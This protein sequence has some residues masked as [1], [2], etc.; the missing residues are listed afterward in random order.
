[1]RGDSVAPRFRRHPVAT[2]AL[3]LAV[4]AAGVV[5]FQRLRPGL[6]PNLE[7]PAVL[8]S[9]RDPGASASAMDR[10]VALP[11]FDALSRLPGLRDARSSSTDSYARVILTFAS[12]T[13]RDRALPRLH[14]LLARGLPL[15]AS[16]SRPADAVIPAPDGVAGRVLV[17]A[18]AWPLPA[19]RRWAEDRLMPQFLGLA[20]V[21]GGQIEGGPVR[22][23][24]VEPDP[25]RLAGLGLAFD[26]VVRAVHTGEAQAPSG[27]LAVSARSAVAAVAALPVRLP[28]G[29]LLPLSQVA[30]VR[31]RRRTGP[32]VRLN[33]SPA[34]RLVLTRM[35]GA[36]PFAVAS[37]I[38]A[39]A[40]WLDA[41]GLVPRDVQVRVRSDLTQS[42]AAL[43]RRFGVL[44]AGALILGLAGTLYPAGP[45]RRSVLKPVVGLVALLATGVVLLAAGMTLNLMVLC[46]L[47]LAVGLCLL[48]PLALRQRAGGPSGL[49]RDGSSGAAAALGAALPMVI[50]LAVLLA[51]P[52][53]VSLLFRDLFAVVLGA[54]CLSWILAAVVFGGGREAAAAGRSRG[55]RRARCYRAWIAGCITRPGLS[56]AIWALALAGVSA[57]AAV[58]ARGVTFFPPPDTGQVLVRISAS[59]AT[60]ARRLRAEAPRIVRIARAQG[61]VAQVTSVAGGRRFAPMRLRVVLAG[62]PRAPAA[63]RWIAGFE[64]AAAQSGLRGGQLQS[65][66]VAFPG[67]RPGYR[68][69]GLLQALDGVTGIQL[70]GPRGPALRDAAERVAR[71]LRSLPQ[72]RDVRLSSAAVANDLVLRLDPVLAA[73][74]DISEAQAAQALR[75]ARGGLVAGSILEGDR[76]RKIR[77]VLPPSLGRIT[78]LPRLLLSGET[79][80]RPAVYLGDVAT[81]RY[82]REEQVYRRDQGLPAISVTGVLGATAGNALRLLKQRI[83]ALSLPPGCRLS[84]TGVAAATQ[85]LSKEMREAALFALLLIAVTLLWRYRGWRRPLVVLLGAPYAGAGSL[86]ALGLGG[87]GLSAPGWVGLIVGAAVTVGLSALT[88]DFMDRTLAGGYRR[89]QLVAAASR[90]RSVV[91]RL[92]VCALAG[93]IP[94][95][96]AGAPDFA[97]LRPLAAALL[98]GACA[99]MAASILWT[100]ALYGILLDGSAATSPAGPVRTG[101]SRNQLPE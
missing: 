1:M 66:L 74:R 43:L 61:G 99:G 60:G 54:W 29:N 35:P 10:H 56:L 42:L 97:L 82:V 27:Y 36:D 26:D 91:L 88:V 4:A 69:A 19:L 21:A 16:A 40:D 78:E 31:R 79:R 2:G 67:I 11:L 84:L 64:R 71:I 93:A 28:D 12:A 53:P 41:N 81:V 23:I 96:V 86:T 65:T 44:A 95:L 94:L 72:V 98:G 20:G 68:D 14:A 18:P 15:P 83:A 59:S 47:V 17:T 45:E 62:P 87:S 37:T 22:E 24:R 34:V 7:S 3:L 80:T 5:A 50:A 39:R 92:G 70:T 57:A 51:V 38:R 90:A 89:T 75:I 76:W 48:P 46:G 55:P 85:R 9:V 52:G 58:L 73:E 32:D 8:V 33:G 63:E 25:Q 6:P 13:G 30:T 101:S 100:P 77:I 49:Q